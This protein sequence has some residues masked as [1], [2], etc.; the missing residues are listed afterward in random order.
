MAL[1]YAKYYLFKIKMRCDQVINQDN[2]TTGQ[3][4]VTFKENKV[5]LPTQ[6]H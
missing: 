1:V 6:L 5:L 2:G 3:V 4:Y